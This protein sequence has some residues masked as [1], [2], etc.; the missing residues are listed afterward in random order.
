LAASSLPICQFGA[1]VHHDA[2]PHHNAAQVLRCRSSKFHRVTPV[3]DQQSIIKHDSSTIEGALFMVQRPSSSQNDQLPANARA[4]PSG[5]LLGAQV[6]GLAVAR[7]LG[8]RGIPV[9]ALDSDPTPLA[10]ASQFVVSCDYIPNP[11]DD[12]AGFLAKLM[13]FG[14]TLQERAVLFPM[15]D[16]WARAIAR[17]ADQ[18]A[19]VFHIPPSTHATLTQVLNKG[20]LYQAVQ[21]RGLSVLRFAYLDQMGLDEAIAHVGFPC[22]VK[23]AEKRH[24]VRHFGQAALVAETLEQL[25]RLL[26]RIGGSDVVLQELI[27]PDQSLLQTVA[28]Y[29]DQQGEPR[30]LLVGHRLAVYPSEFG[31]TCLVESVEDPCLAGQAVALLQHLG[32]R[33]IAEVEF[34]GDLRDHTWKIIDINPRCWK[35]IGLPIAAGVDLPWLAYADMVGLEAAA[36]EPI[37]GMR[38]ASV[39]DL[40]ALSMQTGT[41]LISNEDWIAILQGKPGASIVEATFAADDVLPFVR[42]LEKAAGPSA[43]ACP[44]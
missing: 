18:L 43:C 6:S 39:H 41:S 29:M 42:A 25:V 40:I 1:V 16:E 34:I 26:E 22:V 15:D 19:S 31:T 12:D 5:I 9:I 20:Q 28:V 35:W 38:W 21:A 33:G 14:R 10:F 27:P 32:L 30:G 17:H 36:A 37:M 8:R 44:C 13:A 4:W 24:F 7:S 3:I 11:L 2:Q 23:P